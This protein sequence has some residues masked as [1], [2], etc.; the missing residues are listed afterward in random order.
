MVSNGRYRLRKVFN[1]KVET[2]MEVIVMAAPGPP[3][4]GRPRLCVQVKS[5]DGPVDAAT[6]KQLIGLMQNVQA[7]QGLLVSQGGFKSS[8]SGSP[9]S[10]RGMAKEKAPAEK[11]G[12]QPCEPR[13][14][15]G[16]GGCA[17]GFGLTLPFSSAAASRLLQ[18]FPRSC[19]ARMPNSRLRSA[20]SAV[21][22]VSTGCRVV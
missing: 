21:I 18:P 15:T 17:R 4:F 5:G 22:G 7:D 8:R 19:A 13:L 11:K 1:A 16:Q 2:R 20:A 6:L 9:T 12:P 3:A 10:S 14:G